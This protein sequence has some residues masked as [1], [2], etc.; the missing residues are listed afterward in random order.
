MADTFVQSTETNEFAP[1]NVQLGIPVILPSPV[2]LYNEVQRENAL[3][4]P[5]N[6]VNTDWLKF[7]SVILVQSVKASLP[8]IVIR[9]G[10]LITPVRF[11]PLND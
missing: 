11:V 9:L 10:R 1:S 6:P 7:T 3:E 8:V 2:T 4:F 5:P